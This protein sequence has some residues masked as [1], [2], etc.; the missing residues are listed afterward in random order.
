MPRWVDGLPVL[1]WLFPAARADGPSDVGP[2]QPGPGARTALD[3]EAHTPPTGLGL[4][5]HAPGADKPGA[6][7][8][9]LAAADVDGFSTIKVVAQPTQVTPTRA[10]FRLGG[11]DG[12]R[13]RAG[14]QVLLEIPAELRGRPVYQAV[15]EHRQV[16]SHKSSVPE[17]E[18]K[19][20][21]ATPGVTALHF[22]STAAG[23]DGGW[24]YWNAPW[25][26]SGHDGGKYAEVRPDWECESH[27]DFAKNGTTTV[28]GGKRRHE[29]LSV[30]ALRLRGVGVDPTFVREVTVTF[31]PP[32]ATAVD[33]L[34]FTPGTAIGD[35]LTAHGQT[36]GKDFDKGT[37]P[38]ALAILD[39]AGGG[40]GVAALASRP[41]WSLEDGRLVVELAPGKVLSGVEVACGDTKPDG[42]PNTDGEV[43][44]Q[45]HSRLRMGLWRAGAAEPEWFVADHGVPPK[46]VLFG[47]PLTEH[48]AKAGDR[49]VVAAGVDPTYL[50]AVRVRYTD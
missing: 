15:M 37:Y 46:G 26:S 27:F 49:L 23:K 32:P 8:T 50:M 42:K 18:V 40:E 19:K 48:R 39:G 33:E 36:F 41:G 24:R 45:G 25:G 6:V 14:E 16:Q 47:G 43:G 28:G 29:T 17:G 10:T 1:R 21:D 12:L 7:L 5:P 3:V 31:A 11:P 30:D 38:G 9:R 13:L 22:H 20:W 44:T 4:A 35:L 34:V 2:R